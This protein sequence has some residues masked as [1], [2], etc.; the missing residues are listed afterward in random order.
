MAGLLDGSNDGGRVRRQGDKM[1]RQQGA[2]GQQRYR[3]GYHQV[4]DA[5]AE[6]AELASE[7]VVSEPEVK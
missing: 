3:H 6:V 1:H 2:V 7:D 5:D 4:S